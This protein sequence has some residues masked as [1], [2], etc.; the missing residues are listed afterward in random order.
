[1]CLARDVPCRSYGGGIGRWQKRFWLLGRTA[2]ARL[3]GAAHSQRSR[4]R[5]LRRGLPLPRSCGLSM[6][7]T[8]SRRPRARVLAGITLADLM[9]DHPTPAVAAMPVGEAKMLLHV[10]SSPT[11]ADFTRGLRVR[12]RPGDGRV[13][14]CPAHH[15]STARMGYNGRLRYRRRKR[16]G[17][18]VRGNRS[19][20]AHHPFRFRRVA[21][22]ARL[23]WGVSCAIMDGRNS[24]KRKWRAHNDDSSAGYRAVRGGVFR[25]RWCALGRAREVVVSPGSRSTALGHGGLRRGW[26]SADPRICEFTWISTRAGA[27]FL[28]LGLAKAS[29][30][31]VALVCAGTVWRTT[32]RQLSRRNVPGA[33][34]SFC[35]A[36]GPRSWP[37]APQTTDQLKAYGSH[38]RSEPC[39][40]RAGA[41]SR[42][43]RLARQAARRRC[44]PRLARQ[45][46]GS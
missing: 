23:S 12:G 4:P 39:P 34:S 8:C 5:L 3:C 44:S 36:T 21:S 25:T 35:L 42:Y 15:V 11:T 22:V 19:E 17:R 38:V 24:R 45:H 2:R 14:R 30:R 1:M 40:R 18:R 26:S 7:S 9:E 29:G 37:G 32:T 16:Y 20:A 27:A 41:G 13:L 31:P 6:C 28:G 43:R 46:A 33:R 10:P